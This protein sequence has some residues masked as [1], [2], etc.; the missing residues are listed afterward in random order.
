MHVAAGEAKVAGA[1]GVCCLTSCVLVCRVPCVH[2]IMHIYEPARRRTQTYARVRACCAHSLHMPAHMAHA[3]LSSGACSKV[4][5]S[6][7]LVV[8]LWPLQ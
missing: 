7:Q 6:E 2:A 8:Q 5:C 4:P 1:V 3:P